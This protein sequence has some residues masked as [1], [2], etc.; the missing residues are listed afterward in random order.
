MRKD[1]NI[2]LAL[3]SSLLLSSLTIQFYKLKKKLL[4]YVILSIYLFSSFGYATTKFYYIPNITQ[5]EV[6]QK[7]SELFYF[8]A[9]NK[10]KNPEFINKKDY[11]NYLFL[12][13]YKNFNTNFKY[14]SKY[15]KMKYNDFVIQFQNDSK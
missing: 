10:I 7:T 11:N 15:K 6:V 8:N 2:I 3:P 4:T 5:R 1:L 12:Y 9:L 14:L 13:Y